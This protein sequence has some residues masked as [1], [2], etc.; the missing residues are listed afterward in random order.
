M[1]L[2]RSTLAFLYRSKRALAVEKDVVA[3]LDPGR[4]ARTERAQMYVP[5]RPKEFASNSIVSGRRATGL[6]SPVG[7]LSKLP[8]MAGR[9]T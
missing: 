2:N 3:R 6:F 7:M 9:T 8:E 1:F 4:S 5:A